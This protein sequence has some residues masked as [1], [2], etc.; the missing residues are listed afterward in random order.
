MEDAYKR[1]HIEKL[2]PLSVHPEDLQVFLKLC[3]RYNQST[4]GMFHTL[5]KSNV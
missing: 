4:A 5:I 2:T 3:R 1:Q